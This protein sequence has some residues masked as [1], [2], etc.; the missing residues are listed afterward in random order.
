MNV[1]RYDMH[2]NGGDVSFRSRSIWD[3]ILHFQV[4]EYPNSIH[5][6]QPPTDPL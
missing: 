2:A 1:T 4:F 6:F 3:L 5:Y